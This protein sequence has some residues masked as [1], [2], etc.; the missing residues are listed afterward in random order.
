[1]YISWFKYKILCVQYQQVSLNVTIKPFHPLQCKNVA[2]L[3]EAAIHE[4]VWMAG[5][6][7]TAS[8]DLNLDPKWW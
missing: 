5:F 4:D 8:G 7:C 2:A 3:N 1:M 6:T